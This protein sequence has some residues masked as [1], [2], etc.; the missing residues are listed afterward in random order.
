M[1][2]IRHT[3]MSLTAVVL[4]LTAFTAVASDPVGVY[5]IVEKVIFE[6]NDTN[7]QRVQ[8]WGVFAI[9]TP[10][11]DRYTAP[12]RGY[13]YFT[14][15]PGQEAAATREWADLKAVAGT[16]QGI[17]F[18]GRYFRNGNAVDII[19]AHIT[20]RSADAKPE[21]PDP[22][23]IANGVIKVNPATEYQENMNNVV[24]Q[25]KEFLK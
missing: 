14:A 9:A 11:G 1:K 2:S 15:A 5:T 20:V 3:L 23:P 16:G 6:P 8:V 24:N 19:Q 13:M 25:L 18:G 12:S 7:P 17:A 22:Y 4:G 21:K 10:P